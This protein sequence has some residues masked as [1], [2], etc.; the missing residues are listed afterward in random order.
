MSSLPLSMLW[1][2]LLFLCPLITLIQPH[3]VLL[4]FHVCAEYSPS[5]GK[6]LAF[7]APSTWLS[8]LPPQVTCLVLHFHQVLLKT[9]CPE[10]PSLTQ[11]MK[12][13]AHLAILLLSL[14]SLHGVTIAL[15][16]Y[17]C[18]FL[19]TCSP[20]SVDKL[21]EAGDCHIHCYILIAK[22]M[23]EFTDSSGVVRTVNS[24]WSSKMKVLK[25]FSLI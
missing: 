23:N 9:P 2:H 21:Q 11:Y 6:E 14:I 19:C 17:V 24:W 16:I 22:I 1:P 5:A 25:G 10:R 3:Q 12:L 13:D 8:L 4:L 20:S 15:D 7:A 18:S